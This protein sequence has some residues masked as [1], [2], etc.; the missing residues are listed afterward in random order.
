MLRATTLMAQRPRLNLRFRCLMFRHQ[1]ISVPDSIRFIGTFPA[2]PAP[3]ALEATGNNPLNAM[4]EGKRGVRRRQILGSACRIFS[5]ELPGNN[6][7]R[8]A[9]ER[10]MMFGPGTDVDGGITYDAG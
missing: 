5:G 10:A 1:W 6:R 7:Q 2:L 9:A 8:S 3:H 4:G